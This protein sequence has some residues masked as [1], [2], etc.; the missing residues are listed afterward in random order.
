VV[1]AVT[2]SYV[3]TGG[4]SRRLF[5]SLNSNHP[6]LANRRVARVSPSDHHNLM[7][8]WRERD[9]LIKDCV[10]PISCWGTY[11]H[12]EQAKKVRGCSAETRV[13]HACYRH[14]VIIRHAA[15]RDA[16]AVLSARRPSM[17]R[18]AG[19]RAK[20]QNVTQMAAKGWGP[21]VIQE[22][23]GTRRLELLTS[24]ASSGR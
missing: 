7:S 13:Q 19:G 2:I 17:A 23:V 20:T 14:P 3:E 21:E 8:T 22:M 1:S 9:L 4:R 10:I 6:L 11:P 18:R 24:T 16:V 12:L 5:V 15:K